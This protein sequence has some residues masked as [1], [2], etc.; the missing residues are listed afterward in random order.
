MLR[1]FLIL[2]GLAVSVVGEPMAAT[3]CHSILLTG[4]LQSGNHFEKAIGGELVFRLDPEGLGPEGEVHGWRVS[5]VSS[6]EPDHDYVYP[7]NPPLRFNGLQILG[8]SYGDDTKTSLAHPHEMRFLLDRADYDRISPLLTN[9]LWPYSA[10]RPD[11]AED[12]YVSALKTLAVGQLKFTV[13]AY[14]ADP[15]SGSIRRIEFQGEF[16]TPGN[17]EFDPALKPKPAACPTFSD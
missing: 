13:R 3:S 17:F 16:I 15:A 7:V 14:D 2:L 4:E 5:L 11:K 12:E 8:P 10:P 1:A 6:H 9:A